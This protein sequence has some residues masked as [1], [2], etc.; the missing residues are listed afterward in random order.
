MKETFSAIKKRFEDDQPLNE[1]ELSILEEKVEDLSPEA[2]CNWF[3]WPAGNWREIANKFSSD[4]ENEKI[5]RQ[6]V[7]HLLGAKVPSKKIDHF[8]FDPDLIGPKR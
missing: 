4:S 3:K 2:A 5:F 7:L 6:G 8:S 1:F